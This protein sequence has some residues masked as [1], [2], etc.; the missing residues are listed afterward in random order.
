LIVTTTQVCKFYDLEN[1]AF[2]EFC[3]VFVYGSF[4]LCIILLESKIKDDDNQN[5][6]YKSTTILFITSTFNI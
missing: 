5:M 3:K 2:I 1:D 6:G 4:S